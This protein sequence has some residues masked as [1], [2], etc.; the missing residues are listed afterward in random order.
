MTFQA[1]TTRYLGQTNYRGSRIKAI[2]AAGS[3]TVEYDPALN[4][5]ANHARA[6]EALAN[7]FKW[8]GTW[9]GGVMPDGSGSCF[10]CVDAIGAT[11]EFT[12]IG[13]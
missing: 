8:R 11:P 9:Y 3:I 10:V 12:T 4:T 5:D 7:K 2:A 13:E 1:I 6:A